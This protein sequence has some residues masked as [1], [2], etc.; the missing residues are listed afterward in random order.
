MRDLG[1]GALLG[2]AASVGVILVAAWLLAR[3]PVGVAERIRPFVGSVAPS[4]S[5]LGAWGLSSLRLPAPNPPTGGGL[6]AR[7]ARAGAPGSVSDYRLE[8]LAWAAGGMCV[9]GLVALVMGEAE[10]VVTVLLAAIGAVSG[11]VARD[12]VL[13]RRARQRRERIDDQLPAVA[14]LIAF[15]V[16]AG[17]SVFGALSRVSTSL[18]GDLAGEMRRT[19][20]DIGSGMPLESALTA[21]AERSGSSAVSRFVDGLVLAVDRGTPLAEVL[22]AQAADAQATSRRRLMELAGRKDAA[23]LVPV[24]FLVLP[25][26][27]A[28]ALFPGL[29]GLRLVVP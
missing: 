29:Q 20:A 12:R 13:A 25:T 28:V 17:E 11:T 4:P 26:V 8:R 16:A 2:L 7:L 23:M 21:M 10:V 9:G 3:R 27:V 5:S 14:E 18:D 15:A 6:A 19:V 24:V 1:A 22:R